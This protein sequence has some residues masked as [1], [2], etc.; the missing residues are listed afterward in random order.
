MR[1]W[2]ATKP[3]R[4]VRA[5]IVTTKIRFEFSGENFEG[6]TLSNTISPDKAEDL[7]R[8]GG[9]ETVEFEGIGGVSVGDSGFQIRRKIDDCNGLKRASRKAA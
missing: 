2:E 7:A 6:G 9:G 5:Y 4:K 1:G 3:S 8:S